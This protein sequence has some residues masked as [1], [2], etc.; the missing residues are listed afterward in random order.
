M[1]N[2]ALAGASVKRVRKLLE[3]RA[4]GA[5]A[6]FKEY[7]SDLRSENRLDIRVEDDRLVCR[8]RM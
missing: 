1:C 5:G 4:K 2:A 6:R 3:R 8:G 7:I